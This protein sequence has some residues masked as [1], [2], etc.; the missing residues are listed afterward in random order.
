[1]PR[2]FLELRTGFSKHLNTTFSIEVTRLGVHITGIGV[3][4]NPIFWLRRVASILIDST[5]GK[6][7]FQVKIIS[8]SLLNLCKLYK[9]G[10]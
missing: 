10:T 2:R 5:V 7:A 8:V 4:Y 6:F 3:I 9:V 1:M